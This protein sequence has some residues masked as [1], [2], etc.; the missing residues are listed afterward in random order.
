MLPQSQPGHSPDILQHYPPPLLYI[1]IL[2]VNKLSLRPQLCSLVMVNVWVCVLGLPDVWIVFHQRLHVVFDVPLVFLPDD[3][4]QMVPYRM[5][6][7]MV[8]LLQ[9]TDHRLFFEGLY[10]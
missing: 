3:V 1:F 5:K 9:E 2:G 10:I 7:F 4:T 8:C 6:P